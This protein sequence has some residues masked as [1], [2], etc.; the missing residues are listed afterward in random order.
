MSTYEQLRG[1][2]L[3]FLDQDPAN[4]SNGQVWYNSATG[5]DRVQGIGSGAWS[6]TAP[7]LNGGSSSIGFGVQT[8][9]VI[10]GGATTPGNQSYVE[11]Y[12]GSGFSSATAMPAVRQD[13][14]GAG[15]ETAGLVWC[16]EGGTKL[17]TTIEYD[18]SSWTSGGTYP[19]AARGVRGSGTQTAGLGLGGD[20]PSP[21][22]S[23]VSAEYDGSSWTAGNNL[24]GNRIAAATSGPQTSALATTGKNNTP[25]PSVSNLNTSYDGTN[26]TTETVYPLS[27]RQAAS[28]GTS[29]SA[30]LVAGGVGATPFGDAVT[31]ANLWDGSSWTATGSLGTK[32]T[33]MGYA[34]TNTAAMICRGAQDYPSYPG[35]AQEFNFS[36]TTITAGAWASGSNI[37]NSRNNLSGC[38][39]Q[40]A[41][42]IAGGDS[43]A[44]N[45]DTNVEEYNGT[46][47]SEVTDIPTN[48]R[49][50]GMAGIQ[51]AAVY[52]GGETYPQTPLNTAYLY[53]GTNWTSTGNMPYNSNYAGVGGTGTQ[54][55]ALAVGGYVKPAHTDAVIEFDGSTWST[56]PNNYP[57]AVGALSHCG[58]QTAAL[59]IGGVEYP[60]GSSLATSFTY[61]GSSFSAAPNLIYTHQGAAAGGNQTDAIAATGQTAPQPS[62][63]SQAQGYDGTS[64]SS[65]PSLSTAR[66]NAASGKSSSPGSAS[67][68]AGGYT[69]TAP[70]N[71]HEE[72]TGEVVAARPAQSL[73]T[74]T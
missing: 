27:L 68:V 20:T 49:G 30:N 56:N 36:T 23:N 9:A 19:I 34:G 35:V 42:L 43:P 7:A 73:T 64:W 26:W 48:S 15:T 70:S 17:N 22:A 53:D 62:A 2:R 38:G 67:W 28:T 12:N 40:T 29:S 63:S 21:A 37:N 58:T 3:K 39:T 44:P 11:E 55:A 46:S 61:D 4:A 50:A 72:F 65:R 41:S 51:T 45:Y 32:S 6:S 31:N 5:K 13:G 24:P 16:G 54:T 52:F 14:G 57:T 59:L 8:A 18:G 47:W 1:A 71:A 69:G 60:P 74:S 10:A 66:R 33:H 25:N